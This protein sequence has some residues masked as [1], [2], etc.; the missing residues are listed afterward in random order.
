MNRPPTSDHQIKPKIDTTQ[1]RMVRIASEHGIITCSCGW[2]RVHTREK[3]REDA[4]EKHV[5]KKHN[6]KAFWL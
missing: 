2:Q 6:G 4:A 5:T 3:V 1:R